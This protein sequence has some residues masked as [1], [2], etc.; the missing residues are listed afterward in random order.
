MQ[1]LPVIWGIQQ[2]SQ[3]GRQD[4]KLT[5]RAAMYDDYCDVISIPG[6]FFYG[7]DYLP[8]MYFVFLQNKRSNCFVILLDN[9][10]VSLPLDSYVLCILHE[11]T[12]CSLLNLLYS[13]GGIP[14]QLHRRRRNENRQDGTKNCPALQG[15]LL[16][17]II[18]CGGPPR[19]SFRVQRHSTRWILITSNRFHG[20]FVVSICRRAKTD[21]DPSSFM[22]SLKPQMQEATTTSCWFR[23]FSPDCFRVLACPE[24]RQ[25]KPKKWHLK[26]TPRLHVSRGQLWTIRPRVRVWPV[27]VCVPFFPGSVNFIYSGSQSATKISLAFW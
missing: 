3:H 16:F 15:W 12:I 7:R 1:R 10:I 19:P 18:A 26:G 27:P 20:S 6:N 9:K 17:Q 21:Q 2:G 8:S 23:N 5:V 25:K 11:S 22:V 13:P 24:F 14:E 4:S